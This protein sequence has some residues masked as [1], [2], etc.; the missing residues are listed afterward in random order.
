MFGAYQVGAWKVVSRH[1]RPELVVG[2]SIGALNAWMVA[3]GCDAS[4][5]EEHWLQGEALASP[6]LRMPRNWREGIVDPSAAYEVMRRMHSEL[7]PVLPVAVV[8]RRIAGLRSTVFR[9]DGIASWRHL[10]A[11]CAIPGIFDLQR[12]DGV[13]YADGG[14]FDPLPFREARAL[15]A[16]A[17]L[18]IN[19]MRFGG[20]GSKAPQ[21]RPRKRLGWVVRDGLPWSRHNVERWIAQGEE[22]AHRFLAQYSQSR[23]MQQKTFAQDLF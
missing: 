4:M 15:G 9:D 1:F 13:T 2:V 19:C 11:S 10:A 16:T 12:I 14:L 5:I 6:R 20:F 17:M 22:D 8:A 18:G 7:K 23:Q 3:C 21:I